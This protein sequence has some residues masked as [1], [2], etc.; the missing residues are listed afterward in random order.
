MFCVHTLRAGDLPFGD[1]GLAGLWAEEKPM[2]ARKPNPSM[3]YH[4]L[5]HTLRDLEEDLR[6]GLEGD[7]KSVV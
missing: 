6:W 7:R 4:N 2:T 5:A 3:H 1:A